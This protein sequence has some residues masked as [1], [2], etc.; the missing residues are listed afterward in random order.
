MVTILESQS[1][2]AERSPGDDMLAPPCFTEGRG[3]PKGQR[4]QALGACGRVGTEPSLLPSC[5]TLPVHP[6]GCPGCMNEKA[7]KAELGILS[8]H[9]WFLA[10][11]GAEP[12]RLSLYFQ[13]WARLETWGGGSRRGCA[14]HLGESI[15]IRA[16]SLT[17]GRITPGPEAG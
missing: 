13:L 2:R 16:V 1:R 5:P 11:L 14:P 12:I 9:P 17:P 6:R 7:G 15:A 4:G 10:L 8:S 3:G